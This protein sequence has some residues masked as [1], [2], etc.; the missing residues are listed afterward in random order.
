[1]WLSKSCSALFLYFSL[2]G[3]AE[4]ADYG[5]D[6][7]ND[8]SDF[9]SADNSVNTLQGCT[10]ENAFAL[11]NQNW[12]ANADKANYDWRI[13]QNRGQDGLDWVVH[14]WCLPPWKRYRVWKDDAGNK[15]YD[16]S[17]R[18]TNPE[19][20]IG[21]DWV[22][23][24]WQTAESE[25]TSED[26]L[27]RTH[28]IYRSFR[29]HR[30]TT[31]KEVN[32]RSGHPYIRSVGG[33][34]YC[35]GSK[36]TWRW[37]RT[38]DIPVC[39]N[40]DYCP[41]GDYEVIDGVCTRKICQNNC[42]NGQASEAAFCSQIIEN[43]ESCITGYALSAGLC[44]DAAQAAAD[45]AA[46]EAVNERISTNN[47]ASCPANDN[48]CVSISLIWD[49][50]AT[51]RND[52]DLHLTFTDTD[53]NS[54]KLYYG[55]SNAFGG[56]LDVDHGQGTANAVENIVIPDARKG[57]YQIMVKNYSQSG[58]NAQLFTVVDSTFG[59]MEVIRKEMPAARSTEMI[60]KTIEYDPSQ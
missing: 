41:E 49:N 26:D 31:W 1:M 27:T 9:D 29:S 40:Y 50:T 48:D 18:W 57:R 11:I 51:Q 36:G 23:D 32:N 53:G 21:Y 45:N 37:S 7:T 56:E 8:L 17:V 59:Q 12:P 47:A 30:L 22:K 3:A 35:N 4:N 33:L 24:E 2:A 19:T 6:V 28:N 42:N 55:N 20:Q 52:L 16:R 14:V 44:V 15:L 43:C 34:G 60:V 58:N 38:S 10:P 13:M 25:N 39:P 54:E 46:R 5:D